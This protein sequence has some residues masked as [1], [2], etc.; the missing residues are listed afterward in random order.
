G[1]GLYFKIS[2]S[3]DY[4]TLAISDSE[5]GCDIQELRA[6]NPRVAGRNYCQR[7][8]E[9]IESSLSQDEVFIRLWALKESVLKYTG[10]G[11]SGG[12]STYDFSPY[13]AQE[14]FEAFGCSFY[15]KKIE[16]TYFALC[17]KASEFKIETTDL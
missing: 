13:I 17:Y 5:V 9:L 15:V 8:T 2:H 7:E 6:Y 12:L 4:V 11:L 1:K 10:K 16:N 3:G 14:S